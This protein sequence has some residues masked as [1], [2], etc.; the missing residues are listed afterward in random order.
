MKFDIILV[1][2]AGFLTALTYFCISQRQQ[3]NK[4]K[5]RGSSSLNKQDQLTRWKHM[6]VAKQKRVKNARRE[7]MLRK[8]I[9]SLNNLHTLLPGA[10]AGS[11][12]SRFKES[13]LKF[14]HQWL[15]YVPFEGMPLGVP[16]PLSSVRG[17]TPC[18]FL[19]AVC[20]MEAVEHSLVRQFIRPDDAVLEVKLLTILI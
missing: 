4:F 7:Q 11:N 19:G 10:A 9:V 12:I 2:I 18:S 13:S 16:I 3:L 17:N 1:K 6:E 20:G 15:S 8:K 14:P 5:D